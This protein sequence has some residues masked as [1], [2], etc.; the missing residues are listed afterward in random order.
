MKNDSFRMEVEEMIDIGKKP[1]NLWTFLEKLGINM[2]QN[3]LDNIYEEK[4]RGIIRSRQKW[5]NPTIQY[6][7]LLWVRK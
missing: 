6:K 4:A 5:N 7:T 2:L 3:Q 1:E